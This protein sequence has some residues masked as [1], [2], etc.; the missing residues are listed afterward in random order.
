MD[1][2]S[3]AADTLA[4]QSVSAI[5]AAADELAKQATVIGQLATA[6]DPIAWLAGEDEDDGVDHDENEDRPPPPPLTAVPLAALRTWGAGHSQASG[7]FGRGPTANY[8]THSAGYG[9]DDPAA[10]LAARLGLDFDDDEPGGYAS[11]SSH[12]AGEA[13]TEAST[14][15]DGQTHANGDVEAG[16]RSRPPFS[17]DLDIN[18][19]IYLW[20][21][22]I[23]ALDVDC[24]VAPA[25]AGFTPG[26]STVF[27][28]LLRYGGQD[29]RADL[30]HLDSCRSGEARL[31]KAYGLPCRWFAVTVG[32]KYKE[33]YQIAAQN[34][35]NACYRES[36]QLL[37]ESEL[38]SIAIP[39]A[40]YNGGYPA[41][42]QAN[43]A[44]RTVRKCLENLRH[45][46]EAVVITAA[47]A[48]ELALYEDLMP[49]YFPRTEQEAKAG[50]GTLPDSCWS[51]WGEV[52]VEERKIRV[53]ALI[54]SCDDE[55]D[56]SEDTSVHG[57]AIESVNTS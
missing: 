32:P 42:E 28:A 51:K 3:N 52:S 20:Q 6:K 2:A 14:H 18:G 55:D 46:V 8:G 26:S 11:C 33:K 17:V 50:C 49:F 24:M 39:C 21:G 54:S 57:G 15:C 27:P 10:E 12:N 1:V 48:E 36:F 56:E 53:S 4:R 43:V 45:V 9:S 13:V 22:N 38:A 29:F 16:D 44:L 23:C 7:S 34:T 35:L 19:K 30:K 41:E 31:T 37:A 40:W 47:N 25:A 5:S